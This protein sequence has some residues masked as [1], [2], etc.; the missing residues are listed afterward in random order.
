MNQ[1]AGIDEVVASYRGL[2]AEKVVDR[3]TRLGATADQVRAAAGGDAVAAADI[4][5][6]DALGAGQ[7]Q[8]PLDELLRISALAEERVAFH[9]RQASAATSVRYA[10][11]R[12]AAQQTSIVDIARQLGISRQAV[13]Q[14][15]HSSEVSEITADVLTFLADKIKGTR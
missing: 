13:S 4:L 2:A 11:I 5:R 6:T 1:T 15:V 8:L 3:L 14:I 7:P 10:A 9:Q 12:A